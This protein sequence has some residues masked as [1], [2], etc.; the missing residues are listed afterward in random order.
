MANDEVAG[1]LIA[2]YSILMVVSI[3]AQVVESHKKSRILEQ[4]CAEVHGAR[5]V[6]GKA[7]VEHRHWLI[8]VRLETERENTI[9]NDGEGVSTPTTTTGEFTRVT[10][11]YFPSDDFQFRI[12]PKRHFSRLGGGFGMKD[13]NLGDPSFDRI[14]VVQGNDEAKLHELVGNPA[15]RELMRREPNV[16]VTRKVDNHWFFRMRPDGMDELYLEVDERIEDVDRLKA[17]TLLAGE[18]LDEL[19]SIGSASER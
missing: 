3:V 1:W 19:V 9:L 10:A 6:G 4:F 5:L 11:S 2:A 7:Q 18:F 14:F 8:T 16:S 17:L 15:I 12:Y 13:L